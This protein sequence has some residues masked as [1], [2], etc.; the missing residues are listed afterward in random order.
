MSQVK[1]KYCMAC[2]KLTFTWLTLLIQKSTE[3]TALD[4]QSICIQFF[5]KINLWKK[6]AQDEV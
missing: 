2:V 6:H 5:D 1:C 4:G 3:I